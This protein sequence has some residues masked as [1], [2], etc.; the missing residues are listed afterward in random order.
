VLLEAWAIKEAN[1]SKTWMHCILT[2]VVGYLIGYYWPTL[3]KMT[4]GRVLPAKTSN[5]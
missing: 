2:L 3:A 5:V 1:L 4:A